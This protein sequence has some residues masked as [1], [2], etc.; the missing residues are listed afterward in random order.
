MIVLLVSKNVMKLSSV[1]IFFNKGRAVCFCFFFFSLHSVL[2]IYVRPMML[3]AYNVQKNSSCWESMS[4][5]IALF[6]VSGGVDI[7]RTTAVNMHI[8]LRLCIKEAWL[9]SAKASKLKSFCQ[10]L[11]ISDWFTFE[12]EFSCG[13]IGVS[14]L[15]YTL[16]YYSKVTLK[17]SIFQKGNL[18]REAMDQLE[19][20]GGSSPTANHLIISWS[21]GINKSGANLLFLSQLVAN[22]GL[23]HF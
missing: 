12:L 5:L 3:D 7:T 20:N 21:S 2:Y 17:N 10:S 11:D 16:S 19:Q 13:S 14:W 9:S 18:L 8:F 6:T 15:L 22:Q 23:Q 1:L 4:V